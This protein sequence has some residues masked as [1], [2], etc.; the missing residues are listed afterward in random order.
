MEMD[1]AK[2]PMLARE[3]AHLAQQAA[4]AWLN[5]FT[6]EIWGWVQIV[7]NQRKFTIMP[8]RR[9]LL[10]HAH[11]QAR[12]IGTHF[13]PEYRQITDPDERKNLFIP[14]EALAFECQV[15]D[16]LSQMTWNT[17]LERVTEA[18]KAGIEIDTSIIQKPPFVFGL[19]ILTKQEMESLDKNRG[20]KMTHVER[21]QK[22]AYMMGIKQLFDLPLGGAVGGAGETI[23]DYVIDV[24]WREVDVIPAE[25]QC[26]ECGEGVPKDSDVCPECGATEQKEHLRQA[27]KEGSETLFG[28]DEEPTPKTNGRP[29][30]PETVRNRISASVEEYK[31]TR[32]SDKMLE[33]AVWQLNECFG[34]DKQQNDKR[35]SVIAY[36]F[37]KESATELSGAELKSV[38]QWL[39]SSEDDI[40]DFKPSK[41]ARFE[42]IQI[43][44]QRMKEQGQAEMSL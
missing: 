17:T 31:G 9:G 33:L 34:G 42:A 12:E 23:E 40:G 8:G 36:L 26:Y 44:G 41:D 43:V 20:N 14:N 1:T 6:G 13:W 3:A 39:D 21:C 5:P 30:P 24:E 29:Y 16:H 22:R 4:S 28:G 2:V 10:R 37:E 27:A 25:W 11:E 7:G 35:R 38:I 19:G 32:K 15:K 18:V